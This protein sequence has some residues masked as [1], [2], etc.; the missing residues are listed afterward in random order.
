MELE[1]K[2]L[3]ARLDAIE[4]QS[5]SASTTL[6]E[7]L[8]SSGTSYYAFADYGRFEIKPGFSISIDKVRHDAAIRWVTTQPGGQDLPRLTVMSATLRGWCLSLMEELPPGKV[9]TFRKQAEAH[10]VNITD[11]EK[12]VYKPD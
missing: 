2:N 7:L 10:G 4:A 6:A 1:R 12:L 11:V 9:H 3:A 5:D 8:R